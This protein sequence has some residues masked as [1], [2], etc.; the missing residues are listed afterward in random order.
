MENKNKRNENKIILGDFNF[1][2]DKMDR[3]GE[4][5][6]QRLYWCCSNYVCQ[7]SSWIMDLRIYGDG[8][9]QIPLSSPL[10]QVLWQGPRIDR[11]YTDI[12]IANNTKINHIMVPFTDHYNTIF[13]DRLLSKTKIGKNSW[14]FNNSLL[15]KHEFSSATKTSFLLKTQKTTTLQQQNGENTPNVD[16]KIMLRYFQ[17]TPPL[18]KIFQF[19]D[20]I[21]FFY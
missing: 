20:R 8:R 7:S 14:Y 4:N 9:T 15:C 17:K 13:V 12:K 2:M 19:Q 11:V 21:C 6:T 16:L 1:A 18:K 10:R 5:K 3:N